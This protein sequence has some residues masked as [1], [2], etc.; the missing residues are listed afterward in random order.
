MRQ[1]QVEVPITAVLWT[2]PF[3]YYSTSRYPSILLKVFWLCPFDVIASVL[4]S[5]LSCIRMERPKMKILQFKHDDTL[6]SEVLVIFLSQNN[7]MTRGRCLYVITVVSPEARKKKVEGYLGSSPDHP[8]CQFPAYTSPKNTGK[9]SK[10]TLF[11]VA[12][13]I[14]SAECILIM[15]SWCDCIGSLFSFKL[16]PHGKTQDENF[17]V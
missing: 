17:T 15:S 11:N 12:I 16:Y 1:R 6:H 10:M 13:P 9:R 7:F 5:L 4:Y 2:L 14:L 8:G 3:R